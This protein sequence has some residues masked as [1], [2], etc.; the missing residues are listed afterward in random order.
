MDP[1]SQAFQ[2]DVFL[3]ISDWWDGGHIPNKNIS[4]TSQITKLNISDQTIHEFTTTSWVNDIGG[5]IKVEARNSFL[6]NELYIISGEGKEI[7]EI[8]NLLE[9]KG[10]KIIIINSFKLQ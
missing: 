7:S 9:N 3:P 10:S 6:N 5:G 8:T 4:E 1:N 2:Q